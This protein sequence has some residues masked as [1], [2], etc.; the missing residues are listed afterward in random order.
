MKR[1]KRLKAFLLIII[2]LGLAASGLYGGFRYS[3]SKKIAKVISMADQGMDGYW[4]D[5][6]ESYG[7]VTSE[8]SQTCYIASGTEI[9]SVNVNEGDHVNEG[10]VLMTVMKETQDIKG[11]TLG[12][13]KA[14]E[15]LS[16]EKLK[17]E[18]LEKTK[19]IP[20]YI[21]SSEVYR[22]KEYVGERD[23]IANKDLTLDAAG[24]KVDYEKDDIIGKFYYDDKDEEIAGEILNPGFKGDGSPYSEMEN[25]DM[26]ESIKHYLKSD[27]SKAN[28][29][30]KEETTTES[31][32]ASILYFDG[33]TN[34]IVGEDV[35]EGDGKSGYGPK[36]EGMKPSEL[37]QAIKEQQSAVNKQDL[38]CRR[39]ANELEV[40]E[41]TTDNGQIIAKVSG[42]VS[43][44]QDPDNYNNKQ[45]FIIVSATD[46]YYISGSIGEF[47]LD[48]VKVGDSVSVMSWDNGNSAEAIISDISTSPSKENNFYGGSGNTNVSNYEFKASFDRNSG[49]DIGSAVDI[50]ISPA[51]QE[52][53]GFYIP[54]YFIRKDA[55]GS[56][57]M[58]MNENNTLEKEYV[59]LGKTL[60]G[61]MTEVK[62]GVIA[63]D[64]L[65]FP[66][67]NGEIE[68]IRCE[69]TD[70]FDDYYSNGL[71]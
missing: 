42:T 30:V 50:S 69:I 1:F 3:E 22:D 65:A 70:S 29:T 44:I 2:I 63:S 31:W 25:E 53:K 49:I 54:S 7:T 18:R 27:E 17:L 9:L 56:F 43:K 21:H 41:N 68:G 10:D 15:Q 35:F 51:G 4:G 61:S 62:Q 8:K 55:K 60:W 14:N 38:E 57:V 71:G 23:Y 24:K 67:G 40:M 66:Y 46:D 28:V 11:K 48:S 26:I 37:A 32:L 64:Y 45:P 16:I 12:L 34:Q 5:N 20:E 47:Y 6:I 13:Q 52:D 19:P 33:E 59:K 39:L 36:P 58:K